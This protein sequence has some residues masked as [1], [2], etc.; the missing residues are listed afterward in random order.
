MIKVSTS[1][2]K[3]KLISY[4]Q[5]ATTQWLRS[6]MYPCRL[7]VPFV[8]QPKLLDFSSYRNDHE[9]YELRRFLRMPSS[10]MLHQVALVWT[11]VSQEHIASII[12]VISIGM[13]GTMLGVTSN[14]STSVL[15][16]TTQCN[17][18]EDGIFHSHCH[19]NLKS[20]RWQTTP[21]CK[22]KWYY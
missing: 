11:N 12:R 6:H 8:K 2:H 14:W 20:Y 9:S 21:N 10:G 18:L 3:I 13:L 16:T 17:I 7:K 19:E 1:W 15:T 4:L 5:H 22:I